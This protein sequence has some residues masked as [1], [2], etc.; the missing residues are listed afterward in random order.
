[1]THRERV[2]S[3]SRFAVPPPLHPILSLRPFPEHKS[4]QPAA[5]AHAHVQTALQ[6]TDCHAGPFARIHAPLLRVYVYIDISGSTWKAPAPIHTYIFAHTCMYSHIRVFHRDTH[7]QYTCAIR[8]RTRD[9][10]KRA[11]V[12]TFSRST[13]TRMPYSALISTWRRYVRT[14][15][16]RACMPVCQLHAA[17]VCARALMQ[18]ERLSACVRVYMH[19]CCTEDSGYRT[20]P[21]DNQ[22]VRPVRVFHSSFIPSRAFSSVYLESF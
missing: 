17:C 14:Y 2:C 16:A 11:L 1:V 6:S 18:R 5:H 3:T 10:T 15:C 19:P 4:A 22:N 13:Y 20:G 21:Y 12:Q 7:I 9:C 8:D